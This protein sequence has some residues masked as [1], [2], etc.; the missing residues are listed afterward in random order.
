MVLDILLVTAILGIIFC[1]ISNLFY[2][3]IGID[4]NTIPKIITSLIL[5]ISI[6]SFIGFLIIYPF[7]KNIVYHYRIKL[8]RKDLPDTTIYHRY[9]TK[10]YHTESKYI[11]INRDNKVSYLT[12][13]SKPIPNTCNVD[14]FYVV[15][16]KILDK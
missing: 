14:T 3:A 8:E 12:Y 16:V 15:N 1:G 9:E 7:T 2:M 13:L 5:T 4:E 6:Y 10:M 11:R